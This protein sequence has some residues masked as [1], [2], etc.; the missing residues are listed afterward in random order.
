[1]SV[2]ANAGLMVPSRRVVPNAMLLA[3]IAKSGISLIQPSL[4]F[5]EEG[6][7]DRKKAFIVI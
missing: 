3:A 5:S 4:S 1:V 7:G 2:S 6:W